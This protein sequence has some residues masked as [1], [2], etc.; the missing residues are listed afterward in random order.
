[1]LIN[2]LT[3]A[4][5]GIIAGADSWTDIENFGGQKRDWLGEFLDLEN[6]IPSHDTFGRVFALLDPEQFRTSFLSWVQAVFQVTQGQVIA[7]DGKQLR[8]SHDKTLGKSAI[9]MVSAWATLNHIVLGQVK[10]SAKSNEI[11]AIPKLLKLLDI[12]NCIITIDGIGT[13]TEIVS[14]IVEQGGDYLLPVK[15]NQATLYE[16]IALFFKLAQQ[17]EFQK[18]SHTYHRTVDNRHG[19]MEIR[20]CW[21]ISGEESLLF[22]RGHGIWKNLQTM[23]MI[24]SERRLKKKIERKTSYFISSLANNAQNLLAVKRSHWGIENELHWV[25]DVAFREDDSRVRQ[26][27]SAENLAI[28][29]HMA[30]NLLKQEKTAKGGIKAKRLQAA[31]SND[32]LAKVISS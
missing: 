6:G 32:Y 24:Q 15:K 13:Q 12:S 4:L 23:I 10:V 1:P 3:I 20:Q 14:Q 28:L 18:V 5:C 7:L 2:I 9:H 25:L 19:R 21:A 16:D 22:L 30:V 8:R 11:T 26:G 31:W 29:K 27:N 17:N